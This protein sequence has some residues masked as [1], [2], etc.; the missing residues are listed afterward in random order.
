MIPMYVFSDLYC[1]DLGHNIVSEDTTDDDP[2][3]VY[4]TV[5]QPNGIDNDLVSTET[6]LRLLLRTMVYT[7]ITTN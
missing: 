5:P 7:F 6:L 3:F 4:W 2:A 1:R